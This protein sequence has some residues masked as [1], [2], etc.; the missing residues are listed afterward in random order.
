MTITLYHH[1]Y[2]R[3]ATSVWM[4]EEIGVPYELKFVD[5]LAGAHK[6]PE[7][8]ALNPMGKLPIL[9]DDGQVVTESAA[10]G[11]YLADRYAL[12]RLAPNLDDSARGTYLRWSLYA[13]AVIEPG[14]MA[15]MSDWQ[16]KPS[17]AGWGNYDVMLDAMDTAINGRDFILGA[18]FSMADLIFGGT[19]RYML[20]FKLIE[21][22]PSFQAYVARLT[23]RPA[24]QRALAIN[25]AVRAEHGL[26]T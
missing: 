3:A 2:S 17:Q 26:G 4:L 9:T 10:I 15:K 22:R 23:E 7:I 20:E 12:G 16:F 25:A 8:L 14:T 11:L 24:H 18:Q 13:P 6:S 19:L 1:P 21:A 5:I